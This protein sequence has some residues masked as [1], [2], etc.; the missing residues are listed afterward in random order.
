MASPTWSVQLTF[1][2]RDT[3]FSFAAE[4]PGLA[5][6]ADIFL[7]HLDTAGAAASVRLEV[8]SITGGAMAL[9]VDGV[10]RMRIGDG[11]QLIG[12]INTA[13]LESLHPGIEWIAMIHGAAVARNGR[14]IALPAAC[15]SGK[16]TLTAFLLARGCDYLADDLIA[17]CAPDGRI[18]P[19]PMPIS[20]KEGSWKL[21]TDLYSDLP[22]FPQYTTKRGNARQ[23][24]PA[25]RVGTRPPFRFPGLYFHATSRAPR[26][27]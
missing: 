23:F 10:E 16:T 4:P 7:R 12:A 20:I 2:I 8:R 11:G 3:V 26:P 25:T 27:N 22:N 1:T 15:G 17:L 14:G 21:L 9:V 13:I 5:A 6:F 18:V 19:W 24:V